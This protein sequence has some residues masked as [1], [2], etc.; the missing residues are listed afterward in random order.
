MLSRYH[1]AMQYLQVLPYYRNA[2]LPHCH[3]TWGAKTA[4]AAVHLRNP[5][6]DWVHPLAHAADAFHGGHVAPV[7]R[8]LHNKRDCH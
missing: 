6:L 3:N 5:L 1:I 8:A 7:H 2:K 4:L